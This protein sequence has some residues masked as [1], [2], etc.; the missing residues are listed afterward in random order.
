M[1]FIN[2]DK[3]KYFKLI[4]LNNTCS[5]IF[6]HLINYIYMIYIIAKFHIKRVVISE[7]IGCVKN[8]DD[9]YIKTFKY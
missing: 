6:Y 5:N 3:I 7:V 8:Y 9:Q 2:Y 1:M 4:Y